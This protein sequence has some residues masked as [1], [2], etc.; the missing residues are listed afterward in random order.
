MHT[1][2]PTTTWSHEDPVPADCCFVCRRRGGNY[3]YT[4]VYDDDSGSCKRCLKEKHGCRQATAAEIAKS[5][6]RCPQCKKRG[7]NNCWYEGGRSSCEPCIKWNKTCGAPT[8]RIFNANTW[9][10]M[11]LPTPEPEQSR[12]IA[13][14]EETAAESSRSASA[15]NISHAEKSPVPADAPA[16]LP[17]RALRTTRQSIATPPAP[18]RS[19]TK[20]TLVTSNGRIV[21]KEDRKVYTD[22]IQRKARTSTGSGKKIAEHGAALLN[23]ALVR[24]P[25]RASARIRS[26]ASPL[27]IQE[28][29]PDDS[30]AEEAQPLVSDIEMADDESA[31]LQLITE[32]TNAATSPGTIDEFAPDGADAMQTMAD[33]DDSDTQVADT[34]RNHKSGAD[35]QTHRLRRSRSKPSYVE[36]IPS[37]ASDDELEEDDDE[38]WDPEVDVESI[39]DDEEEF[40]DAAQSSADEEADDE[41][42]DFA[43]VD[44]EP[45]PISVSRRKSQLPPKQDKGL[46]LNSP[47]L[48]NIRDITNDMTSK[49]IELGLSQVLRGLEDRS[50][51][52]ATMCSGTESPLLFLQ[53][54]SE[55]LATRGETPLR[56]EHHFSAE[57]DATKQAYIERN[58]HPP[59]LFRDVRLLGNEDATTAT[60]AYGAEEEIP[61]DLDIL[62]PGFVCKDLSSLNSQK[63]A[64]DDQGETGDTWRAIYFYAKRFQPGI[65]LLENVKSDKRVW[66]DVVSRWS[67][68]GYEAAWVYANTKNYY[69]PQ[70]RQRMYMIAISRKLYGENVNDAVTEWQA[71]MD[72]LQRQ[73]SSPYEAFLVDLPVS[74]V[75]HSMLSSEPDWSLCKLRYDQIRSEQRLGTRRPIT[76]WSENGTLQ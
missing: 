74:V 76:Q 51:N 38:V 6:A 68:I 25:R 65:V 22:I 52:V 67:K 24:G 73:C 20:R 46:D 7:L 1:S 71:T 66:D 31:A 13:N 19:D 36:M 4:C 63:K 75:D 72:K 54:L 39:F 40:E 44:I 29:T 28:A 33:S 60:T 8:K 69:L 16:H 62:I 26:S 64:V 32:S 15:V 49:A 12:R 21:S 45:E 27:R 30:A 70:T 37:D 53:I 50:I 9:S 58:F 17:S 42:D 48:D 23:S 43:D 5:E 18:P 57:I 14:S 35:T 3:A 59:I 41:G 10:F 55:A 34:L 61:G 47:P 2:T 56:V 11:G